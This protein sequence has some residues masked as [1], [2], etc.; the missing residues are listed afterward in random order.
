[1]M[2][3]I[4]L[5]VKYWKQ[6]HV[7]DRKHGASVGDSRIPSKSWWAKK[8]DRDLTQFSLIGENQK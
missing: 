2:N 5:Q 8:Q 7:E 3:R 6:L 1:M 4:I